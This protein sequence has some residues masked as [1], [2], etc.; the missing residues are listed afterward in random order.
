MN[1]AGRSRPGRLDTVGHPGDGGTPEPDDPAAGPAD[2]DAPAGDSVA[3]GAAVKDSAPG[4][5]GTRQVGSADEVPGGFWGTAARRPVV[6]HLALLAVY[7]AA[8]IVVTWPRAAYLPRHQ[9]PETRD[10]SGYVWDLWWTAHQVVHLGNPWFTH[11]MAAPAGIQLGFDTT[12]PLAGLIMTPVTLIFGPSASF[13]LLTIILPGLLC[14]AMYRAAAL[15]LRTPG[16]IAAGALFGL[17]SMLTWQDWYHLNIA[18]GT[19]FLPL[20]LEAAVRLRRTPR[21]AAGIIL[22]LVLGAC[23]LVNQESAVM[24]AILAAAVL[25][26]WL[27][28]SPSRT[29]ITALALGAAAT[30]IV[31]SPQLIAMAQQALAGGATVSAHVLAH[32]GK[33]YGVGL[34]DLVAPTQRVEH[35]GLQGLAASAARADGRIGEGMPMFGVVLT[36]LALGGLAAAWRR[37]SAWLLA[38]LWVGCAW[39][40]LGAVLWIG[41]TPY[42]PLLD[43]WNG[44]RVSLIMPY[45]WLMRIPA[46]SDF[47]EADRFAILGLVGAVLLAGA[48]VDWLSRHAWPAIAVVAALA[49]LEAGWSGTTSI[50]IMRTTMSALDRPIAADHSGS[51]VVDAPFGLRGG[52]PLY[53]GQFPA[54]S[55]ILA[56]ADGHPR[57]VSYTSWVPAATLREIKG[58]PF[59]TLLVRSSNYIAGEPVVL[60]ASAAQIMAARQD[61]RRMGIGWVLVWTRNPEIARYLAVIGFRLD[62]R[63]DGAAVYRPTW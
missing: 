24:A 62:Y 2:G 6:R 56:T 60:H 38:A 54:S 21:P 47:R 36:V 55:L 48:A 28:R 17:S 8:G 46:L 7:L 25:L 45:T 35:F 33:S 61:A 51:I 57:A 39:L 12:M 59:Y 20:T 1:Q 37:R 30:L 34:F 11:N 18:L 5:G 4:A 26:P 63:A 23:I 22:G 52:V 14:Y 44:E 49:V 53:G 43:R 32:T 31:A 29:R 42:V 41:R 27:A 3:G 40:A 50:G 16:A 10:V 15:W 19:V 13:S 58:H 9:L